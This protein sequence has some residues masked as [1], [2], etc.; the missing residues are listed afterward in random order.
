M[1]H[2]H[3]HRIVVLG[4]SGTLRDHRYI[5]KDGAQVIGTLSVA[6]ERSSRST[7]ELSLKHLNLGGSDFVIRGRKH[8]PACDAAE[9]E[10][11]GE[12]LVEMRLCDS[13]WHVG[14]RK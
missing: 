9:Q 14:I 6:G 7:S 8:K 13:R 12:D 4:A 2:N 11:G 1:P 3:L 5:I 10:H